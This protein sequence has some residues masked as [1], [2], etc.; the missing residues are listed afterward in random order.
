MTKFIA[1]LIMML[2]LGASTYLFGQQT[3][4]DLPKEKQTTL[5]LYVTAKEAYKMWKADS[6]KVKT[7]M[8]EHRRNI[9]LSDIRLWHGISRCSSRHLSGM[10]KR[11]IL[12]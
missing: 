1:S 6:S 11:N 5:E 12:L 9:S 10:K 7:W 4:S 3:K 8:F 2:S